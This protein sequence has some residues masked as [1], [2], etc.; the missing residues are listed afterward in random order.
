MPDIHH[1]A[2]MGYGAKSDTYVSGRPDYPAALGAW[3]RTALQLGPGK[4]VVDLGAGTG[5]F[6]GT[7]RPTGA[8]IVA[9][10][11]VAAMLAQLT[12]DNPDVDAHLGTAEAIPLSDSCVDAVICAQAFHWFAT[13]RTLAEIHR[14]L[15]PGGVLGLVWNVRDESVGWVAG[16]TKI[17]DPHGGDVPR[18]ASRQ[19]QKQFP[20][21]GF[22][23]LAEAHFPHGHTGSAED[24]I[25]KRALSVS[26]IAALPEAEHRRVAG[27]VRALVA[28]TPELAGK[29]QVTFPYVTAAFSCQRLG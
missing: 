15:K 28:A 24:V 3:L 20:A 18:Y 5:K 21:V 11:P 26:F 22:A 8:R 13:P 7:L 2:A 10:E 1:A 6:L 25:V 27:E 29:P 16:L 14:V 9:V 19:W 17:I 4:T 23:P 12:R